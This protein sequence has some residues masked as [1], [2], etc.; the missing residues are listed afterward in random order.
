MNQTVTV[1]CVRP[2]DVMTQ[3]G[4]ILEGIQLQR[5]SSRDPTLEDAYVQLVGEG[6]T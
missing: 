1:H 5:V 3:L 2:A 6:E 4:V